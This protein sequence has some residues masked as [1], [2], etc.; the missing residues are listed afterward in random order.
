VSSGDPSGF[1]PVDLGRFRPKK[2]AIGRTSNLD[3]KT[4]DENTFGERP[5]NTVGNAA[6]KPMH[7]SASG[8]FGRKR[9]PWQIRVH[10]LDVQS[11]FDRLKASSFAERGDLKPS[12]AQ[13]DR[14]YGHATFSTPSAETRCCLLLQHRFMRA[15]SCRGQQCVRNAHNLGMPAS[16]VRTRLRGTSNC[17][18][19]SGHTVVAPWRGHGCIFHA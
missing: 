7:L 5:P 18:A 15:Q 1:Q 8:G 16:C 17:R 13:C 11:A 2:R 19:P 4:C 10:V 14:Q 9:R 12:S 3:L 6:E